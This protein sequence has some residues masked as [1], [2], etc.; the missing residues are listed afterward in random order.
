MRTK[1]LIMGL[2]LAVLLVLAL[3]PPPQPLE[4]TDLED[5]PYEASIY[6][7]AYH[8]IVNGYQEA[9]ESWTFRPDKPASASAI[10]QDGRTSRWATKSRPPTSV[11]L[12]DTSGP[13]RPGR[14]IRSIPA[15]TCRR[16]GQR[17]HPRLP[18]QRT[19]GFADNVTRQ[20]A[21][22]IVVRAAGER[23]PNLRPDYT[24]R[25][26]LLL[27]P[28]HGANIK[29]AEYNGL[30]AGIPDLATLG[31]DRER[32][33]RRGGRGACAVV[34]PDRRGPVPHRSSGTQDFTMA[35]LKAL[36]ATAG[37][38]GW[39]NTARQHHRT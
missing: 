27:I 39:K 18:E 24:G 29:K 34:L 11:H 37:Y 4:F 26:R 28:I 14:T 7:L 33:P 38:G 35:Q 9:D 1:H 8:E 3:P 2:L 20:Q 15:A 6:A 25:P 36:P 23:W 32:H 5:N 17:H 22:S 31:R 21:I 30:L 16:G 13:L 19:S 10:R 12:Q